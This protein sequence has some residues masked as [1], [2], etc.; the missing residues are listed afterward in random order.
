[1]LPLKKVTKTQLAEN[2]LIDIWLY[3]FNEWGESLADDYLDKLNVGM[4]SL[5]ANPEIGID[6]NYVREVYRRFQIKKT[7]Y[8]LSRSK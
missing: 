4:N 7:P 1:M 6:C 3:S 5:L 8:F 2:D